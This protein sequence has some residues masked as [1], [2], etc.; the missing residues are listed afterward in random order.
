MV[1]KKKRECLENQT[2][3]DAGLFE[4]TVEWQAIGIILTSF[5]CLKQTKG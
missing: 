3:L 5:Y 1:N 4:L 2:K